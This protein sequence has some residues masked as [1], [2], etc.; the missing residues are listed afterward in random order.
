MEPGDFLL[1]A[2]TALVGLILFVRDYRRYRARK[3]LAEA[4]AKIEASSPEEKWRDYA[5]ASLSIDALENPVSNQT[6]DQK[7][8]GLRHDSHVPDGIKH[9]PPLSRK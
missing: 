7:A 4:T 1:L 3:S 8:V 6:P 5:S 2:P 9:E